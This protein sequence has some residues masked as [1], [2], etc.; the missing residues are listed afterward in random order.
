MRTNGGAGSA[1]DFLADRFLRADQI[2]VTGDPI[3][4]NAN[5]RR[6]R[7]IRI[8]MVLRG[9]PGSAINQTAQT[10][11]PLGSGQDSATG[12]IGSAMSSANDTGTIFAPTPDGRL[13]QAVTFTVH[14]RNELGL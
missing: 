7:S 14:L 12:A 13:R 6:V 5:W 11:Y 10:F 1:L 2:I 8:G 9:P 4:T 3:A